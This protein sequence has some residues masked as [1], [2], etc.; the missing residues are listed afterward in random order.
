MVACTPATPEAS[1]R[2]AAS[3]DTGSPPPVPPAGA[4]D[5]EAAGA[6]FHV[7]RGSP[8]EPLQPARNAPAAA[9]ATTIEAIL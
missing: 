5:D 9:M 6:A 2:A 1:E 7:V 8:E 4:E 3:A